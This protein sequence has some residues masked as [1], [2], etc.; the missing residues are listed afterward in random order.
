MQRICLFILGFLLFNARL[1]GQGIEFFHGT[2][3]E[4]LAKATAEDKL[5]FVD[6]Y[7]EWCGPCK[8]M[9]KNVFTTQ[10]AGSFFNENFICLKIDMEKPENGE[11]ASKFPVSA[12]PT[13]MF[14]GANGKSVLKQVGAM[15]V[16]GL[17][18]FG[19]KG[20]AAQMPSI[21]YEEIYAGGNREPKFLFDYVR[22][23]N[24]NGKSSLKITNDYLATQ[25]DL[26]TPFNLRFLLEGAVEAD[27][28]VFNQ[29][30]QYRTQVSAQEGAAKVDNRIEAACKNTLRKAMEFKQETLLKEAK[31]QMAKN[32]PARAETFA[33]EADSKYFIATKNAAAYL[34]TVRAYQKNTVKN[35]AAKLDG[36]AKDIAKAFPDDVKALDQAI[37]WSKTAAEN[38]GLPDYYVTL[39]SLYKRQG[40]KQ[41]ALAA[42]QKAKEL[43][44]GVTNP[45]L[46]ALIESLQT[47]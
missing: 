31:T 41:L 8:V 27:S 12:Y 19:K 46:D 44:N 38:G 14:I 23:L 7:A 43:E 1:S 15:S 30:V 28:R 21:N 11:F 4:A 40:K 34:K 10:K 35:N 24:R 13:L 37:K 18:E 45:N 16:D 25:T 39:A 33:Y 20:L 6:A 36:L 9:A 47:S 5:I 26:T 3:A 29:L 2:W 22:W 17:L 32:L 42:A